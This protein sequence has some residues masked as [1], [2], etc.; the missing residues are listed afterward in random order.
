MTE[1]NIPALRELAQA[2]YIADGHQPFSDHTWAMLDAAQ[3]VVITDLDLAMTTSIQ[4]NA[5]VAPQRLL[6]AAV[7]LDD[8][9]E[10]VVRPEA[11]SHGLGRRLLRAAIAAGGR[12]FWSHGDL[13]TARLLAENIR[14]KRDRELLQLTLSNEATGTQSAPALPA[15]LSIRPFEIDADE[16]AWLDANASAFADHP[17]QG[18]I[19]LAELRSLEAETWFDPED[20]LL[21]CDGDTVV[22]FNWLKVTPGADGATEGEIY[23]IGVRPEQAGAGLGRALMHAGLERLHDRADEVTLFVEADNAAARH[24]YESLGFRERSRDIHWRV[25]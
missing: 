10:L 5:P 20:V 16:Q 25:G 23:A 22:G 17:E 4:L 12:G 11:R 24:L 13:E 15:G 18:A 19:D 6:A 3:A 2:A 9:F 7:L 8:Q 14:A 1:I 21:L